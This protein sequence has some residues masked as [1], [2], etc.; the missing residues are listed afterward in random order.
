MP[1]ARSPARRSSRGRCA[2]TQIGGP[3]GRAGAG[4]FGGTGPIPAAASAEPVNIAR[5]VS[6]VTR[7]RS[8]RSA[9]GGKGTS[10]ARCSSTSDPAPR[11]ITRRP[12]EMTSRTVAI[13][14]ASSGGR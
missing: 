2:A 7:R 10:K 13:L 5:R 4:L 6:R 12:P 11:P 9:G 14:A 3:P 8:L 1:S